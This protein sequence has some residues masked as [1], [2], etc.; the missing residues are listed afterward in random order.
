MI[1]KCWQ[2][3]VENEN[4]VHC[5]WEYKMMQALWKT[6][7]WLLRKT[8][9]KLPWDPAIPL[10]VIYPKE[11]KSESQVYLYIHVHSGI[12]HSS[13]KVGSSHVSTEG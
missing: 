12:I 5:W 11:L 9:N 6:V 3:C 2:H 10:L 13:Q 4:L 1:N 8:E 7:W